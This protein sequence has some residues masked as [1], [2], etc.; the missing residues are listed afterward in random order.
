[1][2]ILDLWGTALGDL[3][4]RALAEAILESEGRV[5]GA[6]VEGIA[7]GVSCGYGRAISNGEMSAAFG[8]DL[9]FVN[10]GI[11]FLDKPVI[12]ELE[13][14]IPVPCGFRGLSQYLG[15]PCGPIL[16]PD[17]PYV[18]EP[19]RASEETV[20]KAVESGAAFIILSANPCRGV[21]G[22]K[23]MAESVKTI[24]RASGD[25]LVIAGK[26]HHSGIREEYTLDAAKAYME[27]G[28]DG[29]IIPVPGTVPGVTEKMAA[30]YAGEIHRNG[31]IVL[32]AITTSQE[33]SDQETIRQLALSA[34]RIGADI[35]HISTAG[36]PLGSPPPEN[37]YTYS[38]AVR[39]VRHTWNRMAWN[40]RNH[41]GNL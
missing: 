32:S 26:M 30:D 15:R 29:S 39:G 27:A 4:G 33:G 10:V 28:A 41:W 23:E 2:R 19:I 31:G 5:M 17:L 21:I 20:N 7:N 8:A 12:S 24:R 1:M 35:H 40:L 18:P 34:K 13:N 16:E 38:V 25:I 37:L 3:R 11:P 22:H 6:E 36:Y 9:I 14:L